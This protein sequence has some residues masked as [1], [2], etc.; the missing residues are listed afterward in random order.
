LL[1]RHWH[2]IVDNRSSSK[3]WRLVSS[4]DNI[5]ENN[6]YRV[7]T[8]AIIQVVVLRHIMDSPVEVSE[9]I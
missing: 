3:K 1:Q 4:F 8:Y 6:S 2:G 5:S 7:R 9:V